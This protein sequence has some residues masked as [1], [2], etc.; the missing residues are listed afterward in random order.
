VFHHM[1]SRSAGDAW[2]VVAPFDGPP[3]AKPM[4]IA[5]MSNPG[6][7]GV[8]PDVAA[9]VASAA[10]LLED[11]GYIVEERD[12]PLLVRANEICN[13]IMSRVGPNDG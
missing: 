13:Q 9:A 11:A 2:H 6:G 10:K 8:H 7:L 12:A 3:L 1:C 5:V 4:R